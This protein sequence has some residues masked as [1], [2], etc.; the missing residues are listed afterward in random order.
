[1]NMNF[2]L[3]PL[4]FDIMWNDID[5]MTFSFPYSTL[6]PNKIHTMDKQ[7][8]FYLIIECPISSK[9]TVS[10][11]SYLFHICKCIFI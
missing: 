5:S 7:T 4:V 10:V 8:I 9:L 6:C 11:L 2:Y 1:M 3:E